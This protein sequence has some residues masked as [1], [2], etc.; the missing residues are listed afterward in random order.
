MM[1]RCP[2][3]GHQFDAGVHDHCPDCGDHTGQELW[4]KAKVRKPPYER[5][6]TYTKEMVVQN[7][8]GGVGAIKKFEE[9]EPKLKLYKLMLKIAI[10]HLD[11]AQV[12][13]DESLVS[14]E[15]WEELDL[16]Q[17]EYQWF[18]DLKQMAAKEE[19]SKR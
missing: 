9:Q 7:E 10:R 5:P 12:L 14:D 1:K 3:C 6:G 15:D 2:A 16:N 18:V 17:R 4:D 11:K 19:E 8:L 13:P